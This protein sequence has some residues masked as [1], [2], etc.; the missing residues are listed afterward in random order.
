MSVDLVN[1]QTIIQH[2]AYTRRCWICLTMVELDSHEIDVLRRLFLAKSLYSDPLVTKKKEKFVQ[3]KFLFNKIILTACKCRRKLAHAN[4]FNGYID[5]RQSGNI[6]IQAACP[7][8]NLKYEF[9]YPYNGMI[10]QVFDFIDQC[11]NATSTLTVVGALIITAY[12]CSLSYGLLTML[13]IYGNEE[14]A[15]IIKNSSVLVS[16]T[17]LPL[18]PIALVVSRFIS[19]ERAIERFFLVCFKCTSNET[20]Q[21]ELADTDQ[22]SN[23]TE[24]DT[25]E[26]A[27]LISHIRLVLGGLALPTIAVI[28]DNLVFGLWCSPNSPPLIRTTLVG[29]AFVGVKGISKIFYR[30]KKCWEEANKSIQDYQC[31]I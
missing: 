3:L 13:Q 10:L 11:L 2:K 12:W 9:S 25:Q 22:L 26:N 5:A 23:D 14:G 27:K 4:C 20:A 17:F 31:P 18:I 29:L 19:W 7:Q 15:E 21:K 6:N 1:N 24:D 30:K 28:L 16:A 8:C